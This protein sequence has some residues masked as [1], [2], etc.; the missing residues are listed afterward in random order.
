MRNLFIALGAFIVI[1]ASN[2]GNQK[3]LKIKNDLVNNDNDNIK[4]HNN[5]DNDNICYIQYLECINNVISNNNNVKNKQ[6]KTNKK[7]K[8]KKMK[9][10]NN[11]KKMKPKTNL[12]P[13]KIITFYVMQ[14]TQIQALLQ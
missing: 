6:E 13:G 1:Y 10:K 11:I 8:K 2:D 5:N 12:A 9:P 7:K 14:R 4:N 3:N